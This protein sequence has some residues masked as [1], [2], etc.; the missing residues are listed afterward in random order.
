MRVV[1]SVIFAS[2]LLLGS[3]QLALGQTP[4]IIV[5]NGIP[6]KK[7]M[8]DVE[9]TQQVN[10]TKDEGLAYRLVITK[11]GSKYYWTTR[12][13]RE[14]IFSKSGDFYS[15]VEPGCGGYIRLSNAGGKWLYMEHVITGFKNIT[16]WGVAEEFVP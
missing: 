2:L 7:D 16:Y 13:N 12:E 5:V 1:M 15:F 3:I 11:R 9:G 4:S 14:L 6:I 10:L 8:S